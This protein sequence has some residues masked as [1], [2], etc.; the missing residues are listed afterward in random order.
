M[1]SPQRSASAD[2]ALGGTDLPATEGGF[3][4]DQGGLEHGIPEENYP[5]AFALWIAEFTGGRRTS[6]RV[7]REEPADPGANWLPVPPDWFTAYLRVYVPATD[8][9]D[10]RWRPPPITPI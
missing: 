6:R 7:E 2:S 1:P 3:L 10:G 4:N 9:L 8:V 5:A